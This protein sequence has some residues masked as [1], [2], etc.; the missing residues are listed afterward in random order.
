MMERRL[1]FM[2][3]DDKLNELLNEVEVPD[4]LSPKNIAEMLKKHNAQSTMD[5][6]QREIKSAPS[7]VAQRRTILIRT[8]A[9]TAA[10]AVFAFG[11]IAFTEHNKDTGQ[12][13]APIDYSAVSPDSYD[14]LYNIYTGIYLDGNNTQQDTEETAKII[15]IEEPVITDTIPEPEQT[16]SDLGEFEFTGISDERIKRADIAKT[17]GT[18]LYCI[19]DGKLYIISLE[20]MEV[21]AEL[22]NKLNP[23]IEMYIDGN[24]L[25][26]VSKEN[27]EM[28][29][30]DNTAPQ[31]NSD[32]NSQIVSDVPAEDTATYFNSEENQ[33][34][35]NLQ[36]IGAS[37]ENE[38][39]TMS[40]TRDSANSDVI[41]RTNVVVDIYNIS[42]KTNPIPTTT[43]KQNGTYISSKMVDGILY[44]ITSY[45]DYRNK[46]LDQNTDLDSY[47]PAYYLNGEKFYVAA[48]DITIP[49]NPNSTDYTVLSSINLDNSVEPVS[50][51]AVLGSSKNVYCSAN[52]LYIVGV[53]KSNENVDYSIITC[54]DL[55]NAN[56][57]RYKSSSSIEGKLIS[58][59]SMNEYNGLF[60]IATAITDELGNVSTSVY[61]LDST[62]TV[63]NSAGQLLAGEKVS[64]VRFEGNYA[65]LYLND[66][67]NPALVVDMTS[68]P[69]VQTQSLA[70]SSAYLYSYSQENL[71]GLG[72]SADSSSYVLSMY[73]ADKGLMYNTITFAEGLADVNSKAFSDRRALLV[74]NKNSLIGVPVYGHNEFGTINQYYVFTYDDESGF[75]QKGV[76][77]YNDIDDSNIFERAV[78]NGDILYVIGGSR[79]VSVQLSDLKV[80]DTFEF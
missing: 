44:T 18:N 78:V 69:P 40:S 71:L 45:C 9:A 22:D 52:T 37:D 46:P 55:S 29:I 54:F 26:L 75:I 73:S 74:D 28:Q 47:V 76:I 60:R 23:P 4:E 49:S 19:S 35:S 33:L 72:K 31:I 53:G 10:C 61:V 39:S 7:I 13:D 66:S 2:T 27:E 25:I 20:T 34:D 64:V 58:P 68:Q 57:M 30:I 38:N 67:S 65:S 50:V 3:F 62:L 51:K 70:G 1:E 12:I 59:F 6:E 24:K 48:S 63:V 15:P 36:T 17:D 14:D 32:E 43:Y 79:I 11:M 21:I 77:E 8:A 41:A 56:D 5:A 80:I 42:D 16:L